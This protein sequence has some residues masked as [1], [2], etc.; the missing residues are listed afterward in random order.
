MDDD[1][2]FTC[3]RVWEN[4]F[5][6]FCDLFLF[7]V[8]LPPFLFFARLS[9]D[10]Q[11][12]LPICTSFVLFEASSFDS[13]A[14]CLPVFLFACLPSSVFAFV[15]FCLR[16]F[17]LF[18]FLHSHRICITDVLPSPLYQHYTPKV[19]PKL[20]SEEISPPSWRCPWTSYQA[21][22]VQ[23]SF[24]QTPD[25]TFP[26]PT[27]TCTRRFDGP[28]TPTRTWMAVG[29]IASTSHGYVFVLPFK[30][31]GC[32]LELEWRAE[33]AG[34]QGQGAAPSSQW[35]HSDGQRQFCDLGSDYWL[36]LLY[37]FVSEPGF[38]SLGYSSAN[39]VVLAFLRSCSIQE[40]A[41]RTL[42]VVGP[43][44]GIR[45]THRTGC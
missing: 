32:Y 12:F 31:R 41:L 15:P 25:L 4:D 27:L 3:V 2:A 8:H 37:K 36:D 22:V 34:V 29:N 26:L 9:S 39:D 19:S 10:L 33:R 17:F 5:F 44:E 11:V 38:T 21:S 23:T 6:F 43:K 16:V 7:Q 45:K 14:I 28:R 35:L 18:A 1:H 24:L 42:L 20:W 13:V 40:L 30:E